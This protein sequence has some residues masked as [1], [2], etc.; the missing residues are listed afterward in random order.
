M[1]MI[2]CSRCAGTGK[3][4]DQRELGAA[5]RKKRK[6]GGLSLRVV[7]KRLAFSPSYISDLELGRRMWTPG[8]REVYEEMVQP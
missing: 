6:A 8:M 1:K 3:L 4:P 2:K 7:A 5:M